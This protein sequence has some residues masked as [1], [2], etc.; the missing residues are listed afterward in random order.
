MTIAV[1]PV[2]RASCHCGAVQI[3]LTLPE[4]LV[5]PRHCT[6]S[7]CR[8]RGAIVVSVP[9]AGLRVLQGQD[10][11]RL[12][13]FNTHTAKHYFCG[14]CGIYTHHQR[15]SNPE[16]YS[17]NVG[18]LAGVTNPFQLEPVRVIDGVNHPNDRDS[19]A[20][21]PGAGGDE[22]AGARP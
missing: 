17:V 22:Q 7:M 3:A 20:G 10:Q 19:T 6:C 21:S 11:L 13:Q 15:R 9:L 5:D 16:Q 12:Y 1:Q 8:R 18:C 14:V 4:G 2:H